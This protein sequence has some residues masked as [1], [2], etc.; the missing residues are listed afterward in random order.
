LQC[1]QIF[2]TGTPANAA[3][4]DCNTARE[5][6]KWILTYLL[7]KAQNYALLIT[8]KQF[9]DIMKLTGSKKI[10]RTN[11]VALIENIWGTDADAEKLAAKLKMLGGIDRAE[12]TKIIT[13]IFAANSNAVADYK[14]T[15]DKVINFFMGQTMKATKGLADS[16][17]AKEIILSKLK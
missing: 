17:I 6:S 12:L 4:A 7:A 9:T 15:P 3:C 13:G 1:V 10:S 2:R 8:P 16:I 5:I 14:T 11:A